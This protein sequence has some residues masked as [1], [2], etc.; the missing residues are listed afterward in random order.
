MFSQFES[1]G[2]SESGG[3]EDEDEGIY[4]GEG[5]PYER[6]S[7]TFPQRQVVR[8]RNPQRQVAEES[9]KLSMGK[10]LNVVVS[11]DL[12]SKFSPNDEIIK[13]YHCGYHDHYDHDRS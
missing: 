13:D 6:S 4:A 8:E 1:G 10:A 11:M 5:I 3:C 2:A 7:A 12:M 9:P